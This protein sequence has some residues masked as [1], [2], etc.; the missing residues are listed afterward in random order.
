MAQLDQLIDRARLYFLIGALETDLRELLRKWVLPYKE[1]RDA[2][3]G[4]FEVLRE[5]ADRD[6]AD[7]SESVLNYADFADS[8]EFINRHSSMLPA[9]LAAAV[10]NFT[11]H[12][13]EFVGPRNRVMHHRPLK[14]EDLDMGLKLCLDLLDT[15]LPLPTTRDFVARVQSDPDWNPVIDPGASSPDEA[16]NNL[17]LPEFDETGLLG[18]RK[19]SEELLTRLSSGR[20]SIVTLVGEGGMGKTALAVDVLRELVA[21]PDCPFDAVLWVSL[22]TERLT[23]EGV[24]QLKGAARD[25]L[26]AAQLI[27]QELEE[28]FDGT[29]GQLGEMLDG[30][31]T[32]IAIDNAESA[33][34]Q[35]I[36]AFYDAMPSDSRILLTSRVGLGQLER[37]ITVGPL[38]E[39]SGVQMLRTLAHRRGLT[40][41]S[42]LSPRQLGK[43][44]QR[45][46][47]TPLAI[48]WYVEAV[49]AGA[50]PRFAIEDQSAL[51]RFCLETIYG[52]LSETA[53]TCLG[54]LYAAGGGLDVPQI[55]VIANVKSDDLNRALHDL[56]RRS[57]VEVQLGGAD[58]LH[59]RYALTAAT[60][61]YLSSVDRP[62]GQSLKDAEAR[63]HE[64]RTSEERRQQLAVTDVTRPDYIEILDSE[65]QAVAHLLQRTAREAGRGTSPT[66]DALERARALAP[67]FYEVYRV[68]GYF[69]TQRKQFALATEAYN[70]ALELAPTPVAKARVSFLYAWLT[71]YKLGE[72]G[73]AEDLARESFEVLKTAAAQCRLAHIQMFGKQFDIAEKNLRDV[74][75]SDDVRSVLI[76][77]T[78]LTT[79]ASRR[80]QAQRDEHHGISAV[81]GGAES[82]REVSAYLDSGVTDTTLRSRAIDLAVEVLAA[83]AELGSVR[84]CRAAVLDAVR[85][86]RSHRDELLFHPKRD[87]ALHLAGKISRLPDLSADL[88]TD[89]EALLSD[90]G[91]RGQTRSDTDRRQGQV[92]SYDD[93][94]SYGFLSLPD[95]KENAFFHRTD[96]SDQSSRI[97]LIPGAIVTCLLSSDPRGLRGRDVEPDQ[98][99]SAKREVL[100][101][102]F[103]AVVEKNTDALFLLDN[104]TQTRIRI[105]AAAMKPDDWASVKVSD[106]LSLDLELSPQGPRAASGTVV[107][108][109]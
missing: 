36:V 50:D 33:D 23:G 25:V 52:G 68:E 49:A 72:L 54:V 89:I 104:R 82:L 14:P 35:E 39:R 85:F 75:S 13:A 87:R 69:A 10:R 4:R 21:A 95:Q 27:G 88:T 81:Q 100:T 67:G 96:I 61:Q 41:L 109:P 20:D 93:Q 24:E 53:R 26:G 102:C 73:K 103:G 46:R 29:M 59:Q 86:C 44:V 55:A 2:F 51:L 105:A 66:S 106:H 98:S 32:L 64:L 48:R 94:K 11:P 83:G 42:T 7:P 30:I 76:A 97:F 28:G 18:R 57:L 101:E 19:E 78:L 80:M 15:A 3:G 92:L 63:I 37:R 70:K 79:L 107:F 34:S 40:Q 84:E 90:I 56:Q 38:D 8:F 45:L 47:A 9:E 12:L 1:E 16:L 74:A 43:Q 77:R 65:H 17:P 91:L 60:T 5:R 99:D 58:G 6:G 71:G 22:K 108:A 31:R 62:S